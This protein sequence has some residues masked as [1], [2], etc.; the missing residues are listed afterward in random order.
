MRIITGKAKGCKLQAPKGMQTRPTTDRVKE[1]LFNILG[2]AVVDAVVLDIFAGSG[3]LGLEA[4]SRGATR[5]VFI[6]SSRDSNTIISH[7]A[8]HTRL[9]GQCTLLSSDVLIALTKLTVK[10]QLFDLVFCDP[11]YNQGFVSN[12]LAKL[13]AGGLLSPDCIIV[14]E[15]SRHEVPAP[16][17]SH[18][19]LRRSERYG[20]TLL[21]FFSGRKANEA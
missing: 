15:H 13:D 16:T 12:V 20:E 9:E 10:R 19:L 6:D 11:P 8:R 14:I 4:L 5:A 21:S 7:N 17:W 18:F 1:S 3:A 2:D